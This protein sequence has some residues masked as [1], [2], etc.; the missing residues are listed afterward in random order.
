MAFNQISSTSLIPSRP[1]PPVP[2]RA[3]P[4]AT[5]GSTF[6]IPSSGSGSYSGISGSLNRNSENMDTHVVRSGVVS[7]KE[8]G[9]TSWLWRTKWLILK[10]QTLSMHNS[11]R[12]REVRLLFTQNFSPYHNPPSHD[13]T[14][15]S[16]SLGQLRV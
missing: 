10:E 8:D 14:R 5:Y 2:Q 13:L 4:S 1:A 15:F 6:P 3:G 7:I 11:I 9:L 12:K 16:R